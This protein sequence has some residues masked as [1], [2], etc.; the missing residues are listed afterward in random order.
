MIL[1]FAFPPHLT[2]R[3]KRIINSFL[4]PSPIEITIISLEK[5]NYLHTGFRN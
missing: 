2:F 4:T 1:F 3:R 5:E